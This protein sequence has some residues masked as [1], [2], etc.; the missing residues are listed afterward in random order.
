MRPF[1]EYLFPLRRIRQFAVAGFC[2][3]STSLPA[4]AEPSVGP[5]DGGLIYLLSNIAVFTLVAVM[6]VRQYRSG[7]AL[8]LVLLAWGLVCFVALFL[9]NAGLAL[10]L[11]LFHGRTM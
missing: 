5:G 11:I 8:W 1:A 4:F 10:G 6:A 9:V 2:L 3:L 7:T